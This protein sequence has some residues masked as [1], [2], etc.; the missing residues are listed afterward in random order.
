MALCP[1]KLRA[2]DAAFS[3][4]ATACLRPNLHWTSAGLYID[5]R[6]GSAGHR[7]RACPA[8]TLFSRRRLRTPPPRAY[9][10]AS[11]RSHVSRLGHKLDRQQLWPDHRFWAA[12]AGDDRCPELAHR[13]L[14]ASPGLAIPAVDSG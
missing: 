13:A 2:A 10:A 3:N 5:A 7:L 11:C 12:P 6:A 1:R 8:R 14:G 4:Y 9:A